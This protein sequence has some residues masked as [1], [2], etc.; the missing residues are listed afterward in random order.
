MAPTIGTSTA[1]S[2][3]GF[4][5]QPSQTARVAKSV[6]VAAN[7]PFRA[8]TAREQL[9]GEIREWALW[10]DNWD[11]E[12]SERP[13]TSSLKDATL[14]VN[15]M[16]GDMPL[17]EPMLNATGTAGL[18]WKRDGLYADVEFLGNRRVAYYVERQGED[19]HKG[20]IKLRKDEMPAVFTAVISV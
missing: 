11:G 12:G 14:F 16:P 4:D 19:K 15:L 7:D 3:H 6:Q 8:T 20:V 17:P 13:I 10:Q 18:Y 1:G 2:W 5:L 9:I